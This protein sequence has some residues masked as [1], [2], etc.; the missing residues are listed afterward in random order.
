MKKTLF[1]LMFVFA[2]CALFSKE[3]QLTV[4]NQNFGVVK[5]QLSLELKKGENEVT[6]S[7]LAS[8]LEPASVILRDA[9]NPGALKILEQNFEPDPLSQGKLLSKYEGKLLDFETTEYD[10]N[11]KV[12]VKKTKTG[13]VLR[14]GYASGATGYDRYGNPYMYN[15]P[16]A[17]QSSPIIEL[18]GK[19][20]F[21]LPGI[22]LFKSLGENPFINP[23]LYWKLWSD[24]GGKREAELSYITD[25][26]SWSAAYDVLAPEK[27]D[28]MDVVGWVNIDNH[29]GKDFENAGVKLMAGD[30]N[31]LK[32]NANMNNAYAGRAMAMDAAAANSV[33]QK[34]FDEYH[35]YTLPRRVNLLDSEKKQIEFMRVA[36]V[37]AKRLYVY[38]GFKKDARFNGYDNYYMRTQPDLG[39]SSG[40]DVWTMME[41]RNTKENN[42]GM[43]LPR[44]DV[45]VYRRDSDGRN[46]FVGEDKIDHTPENETARIYLG[47]AFD[48]VGERKKAN[49]KI[50][51]NRS[52][53]DEDFSIVLRNHKKEKV[54]VNVVEHL[55]RSATWEVTESSDIFKKNDSST[56]EFRVEVEPEKDRIVTYH[57]NYTW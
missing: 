51:N 45:K 1:A 40:R 23:T 10:E 47:N 8:Q 53:C 4:Y 17:Y 16:A 2:A 3:T 50:D 39:S 29:C 55:Y 34:D 52:S 33:T 13:K 14:S 20:L 22:P 37:K 43:P 48:L 6:L 36:G 25:G 38:D 24:E 15:Q 56:I 46:E 12:V 27:G 57:V 18:D 19:M 30:P 41:F 44:G 32:A 54:A 21:S 11:L 35:M 9:A 31:K 26:I 28:E 42:L 7:N 5:E 49:F